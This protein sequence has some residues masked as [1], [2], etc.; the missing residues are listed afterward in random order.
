VHPLLPLLPLGLTLLL[1]K[2]VLNVLLQFLLL[3]ALLG[4]QLLQD[5]FL[6]GLH[7]QVLNLVLQ[8]LELGLVSVARLILS[9][10]WCSDKQR[11]YQQCSFHSI[12]YPT[13]NR[14]GR[15]FHSLAILKRPAGTAMVP[16]DS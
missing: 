16:E 4:A 12:L 5:L 9:H 2:R 14:H 11:R 1:P 7:F 6:A 15:I 10:G 8:H 3:Q 13:C